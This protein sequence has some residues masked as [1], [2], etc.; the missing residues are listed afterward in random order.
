MVNRNRCMDTIKGFACLF[1][2][3]IHY[4]WGDELSNSLKVIGRF[5][6]PYFYFLAGYYIPDREGHING[7]SLRKKISRNSHLLWK[8]ALVY[9]VFCVYWNSI[10]DSSWNLW[11]FTKAKVVPL[12][13]VKLPLSCDPAVYAHLWYLIASILC[14][15][16]IF[17]IYKKLENRRFLY[18]VIFTVLV[19]LYSMFAEFHELVGWKKYIYFT[20]SSRLVVSNTFILRAMPFMI[21]GISLKKYGVAERKAIPFALLLILAFFGLGMSVLEDK[22]FGTI[23]MYVG[24]H[25]AVISLALLSIWYPQKRIALLDYIGD[26]LSM[27]VYIYHIAVGKVA[28]LAASKLHLW[29]SGWFKPMHPLIVLAGSLLFAQLLVWVAQR[30]KRV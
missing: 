14:Y 16:V 11:S 28:D 22:K 12:W 5:A 7:K 21:F 26:K 24:T 19:C 15:L 2:V 10:M 1:V 13:L 18:P 30:K 8:S 17:L 29:G 27:Y 6:V 20:E 25:V 9:A 23:L 3:L 4:N